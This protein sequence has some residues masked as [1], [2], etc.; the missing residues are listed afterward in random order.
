LIIPNAF[1]PNGD[2]INEEF[3]IGH[4]LIKTFSIEIFDRWGNMVFRSN[5]P[6]FRWNGTNN[7]NPLPEGTFIYSISGTDITNMP[8]QQSGSITLIK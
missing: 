6:D 1:T 3:F 5:N 4:R 8:V 2:G 7:G